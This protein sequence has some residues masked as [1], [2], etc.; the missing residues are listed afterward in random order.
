VAFTAD[1]KTIA[2][3]GGEGELKLWNVNTRRDMMTLA[4]E[5]HAIFSTGFAQD[6]RTLATVS[7]NHHTQDCSLKLWHAP[8][9]ID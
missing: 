3:G 4:A 7:F 6:G 1:G 9:L 5:Q 2:V 8:D